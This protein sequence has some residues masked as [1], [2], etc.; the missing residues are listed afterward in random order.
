MVARRIV[1]SVPRNVGNALHCGI[2]LSRRSMGK[3][4][5][6]VHGRILSRNRKT[7]ALQICS[8][9]G[10]FVILVIDVVHFGVLIR[11]VS[12]RPVSAVL[13]LQHAGTTSVLYSKNSWLYRHSRA[14]THRERVA[15]KTIH[16]R[17]VPATQVVGKHKIR[18]VP[19]ET[20]RFNVPWLLLDRV[21]TLSL[22]ESRHR[23]LY[24]PQREVSS[25][26]LGHGLTTLN[27]ELSTALLF[28][29]SY[30]HR[31]G[32]Y[33]SLTKHD[34]YAIESVFGWG[35]GEIPREYL[36]NE[37]CDIEY[38]SHRGWSDHGHM[39]PI[40]TSLKGRAATA[41]DSMRQIVDIPASLTY[42][43]I[44]CKARRRPVRDFLGQYRESNTIFQLSTAEC[45]GSPKSP[46]FSLS[47][48][49]FYWKYWD[50][51]SEPT[52]ARRMP[53]R[54][55]A[56]QRYAAP[57]RQRA[58]VNLVQHELSIAVHSR[59]GDF[60]EAKNRELIPSA[61]LVRVIHHAMSI[62][63]DS[64]GK[65]S[66]MPVA[67]YVYSEGQRTNHTVGTV[68]DIEIQNSDYVDHDGSVHDAGWWQRLM[69]PFKKPGRGNKTHAFQERDE[70]FP[71]GVRTE[72]RV[73]T[74]LVQSIHE[75]ASAD[76]L[77]GSASDLSQFAVRV[78]SRG[79]LQLLP[80]YLGAVPGLG[81]FRFD[82][83]TGDISKRKLMLATWQLYMSAN[84]ASA[85]RAL[86]DA[87]VEAT[88]ETKT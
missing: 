56:G 67:V 52:F 79:G 44:T 69:V 17:T 11:E 31:A 71:F 84:E 57:V 15:V 59:R 70:M 80:Q 60:F 47:H 34:R 2:D 81:G 19:A 9:L 36:Q 63:R 87:L 39:C 3:S 48:G 68:H 20:N 14:A 40:C 30:S 7:A 18:V 28:N 32:K 8:L 62:V 73:A 38:V 13:R 65:F 16:T 76:I 49:F 42:G 61:V 53:K 37:M 22:S 25:D 45:D 1:S 75:M 43:C 58:Q 50:L 41:P 23:I 86:R 66:Q 64:G 82:S 27:S 78:V 46:D 54:N 24:S 85:E 74:D 88:E 6:N 5:R 21:K 26:G 77:I 51:H 55:V 4:T 12:A 72:M 29:L 35:F 83:K 10:L 33:A